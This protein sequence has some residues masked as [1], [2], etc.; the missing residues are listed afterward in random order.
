MVEIINAVLWAVAT[1]LI[2]LSGLY[3]SSKLN[4]PQFKFNKIFKALFKSNHQGVTPIKTL[5]LTLAGRIGVGSIAGVAL[6]IYVGGPGTIFWMWVIALISAVLAYAETLMAAKYK[7]IVKGENIGGPFYYIK[8]GL[9]KKNLASIY[10]IIIIVAYL[11]G[12]I[13]IQANTITKS[14][15]N[16]SSINYI[17]L[18]LVLAFIVYYIIKGGLTKI[19]KVT[20]KIVPI[21]TLLY[22]VMVLFVL[23][24]HLNLFKD[25]MLLIINSAFELKPFFSG[26]LL[27]IIIGIERG[28]FSNES[29]LGIGAIATGASSE[30]NPTISG[31][32]QVLGVYITTIIICTATAFMI[33]LFDYSNINLTSPNG[34]EITSAAFN[35]HFGSFGQILLIISILL[36]AFST[37][38][39]GYYYCEVALRFLNE[40]LDISFLKIATP[41]SVFIGA[42]TSPTIIWNVIDILVAILAFINI[43]T[44]I[45]LRREILI[46]HKKYDLI[47]T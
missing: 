40:K 42:V 10:A 2:I 30:T 8:N 47:K 36:F 37:V 1:S 31:Y 28:I 19:I 23:F 39:T 12:F 24:N 45:K 27:T 22:V 46:Y 25:M 15:S 35:F 13:P 5:F 44:L 32:I 17:F 34:I 4:Y 26:F 20:D 16:T 29:G 43:Y 6:A 41:I 18:G 21:M 9:N 7:K 3:F 11:F 33:L 14:V 38:L